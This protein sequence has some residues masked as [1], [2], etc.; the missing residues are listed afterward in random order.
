LSL[1]GIFIVYFGSSGM[2]SNKN[3]FGGNQFKLPEQTNQLKTFFSMQYLVSKC[4]N[5]AGQITFPILRNDVKCFG[6][7]DCFPL[8]FGAPSVLMMIVLLIFMSGNSVYTHVKPFDNMFVRVCKCV[9]VRMF[10]LTCPIIKTI[11]HQN[12]IIKRRSTHQINKKP[13][14]LD[15][16]EED[17]G[18]QLVADTKTV[19]KVIKIFLTLPIYFALYN[20]YSS[21]WIFQATQMNGD[22]GFFTIKPD[23]MSIFMTISIIVLIPLFDSFFYPILAKV[24]VKTEL[25]KIGIGYVVCALSFIMAAFVEWRIESSNVHML[26]LLPQLF[27]LAASD[28]FVWI[29]AVNFAYTQAPDNMKSVITSFVFLTVALGSLI[30]MIVSSTNFIKS[31]MFEFLMYA[32]LMVISTV[33]FGFISRRF[34]DNRN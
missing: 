22:L 14:W 19:L 25:Q 29:S 12:A 31:Q 11:I 18:E 16:A 33:W 27:L 3:V 5:L 2:R 26:W 8:A 30:V 20:Q 6:M 21:R 23:Q 4:G 34:H 10:L 13:H 28:V 9:A 15:Y 17:H 7:D 32:G 24:G 1:I